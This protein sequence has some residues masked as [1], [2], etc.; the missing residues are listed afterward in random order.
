MGIQRVERTANHIR[1]SRENRKKTEQ[2][3]KQIDDES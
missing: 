2:I 1:E 3:W